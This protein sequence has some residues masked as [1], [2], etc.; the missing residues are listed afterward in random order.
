MRSASALISAL[1]AG[2]WKSA[3]LFMST[4]VRAKHAGRHVADRFNSYSYE[5][6]L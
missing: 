4:Y 2:D 3:N 6:D 5:N 1:E